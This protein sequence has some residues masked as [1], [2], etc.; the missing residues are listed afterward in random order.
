MFILTSSNALHESC[1]PLDR[2]PFLKPPLSAVRAHPSL[3]RVRKLLDGQ[4]GSSKHADD[5]DHLETGA[6]DDLSGGLAGSGRR[7]TGIG[8]GDGGGSDGSARGSGTLAVPCYMLVKVSRKNGG[9]KRTVVAVGLTANGGGGRGSHGASAGAV[10]VVL[11]SVGSGS[12]R[13]SSGSGDDDNGGSGTGTLAVPVVAMGLAAD[14]LGRRGSHGAGARGVIVVVVVGGSGGG[15]GS[16]SADDVVLS[17]GTSALAVPFSQL[18][19]QYQTQE[20]A[21]R[22]VVTMRLT[23]I[24]L[25]GRRGSVLGKDGREETQKGNGESGGLHREVY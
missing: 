11:V 14:G 24:R 20:R 22:T 12:D 4:D 7:G 10:G 23:A 6:V 9:S 19:N 25:G 21:V 13:N 18:A 3:T 16:G 15:N 1:T 17:G 5:G 8:L 2:T